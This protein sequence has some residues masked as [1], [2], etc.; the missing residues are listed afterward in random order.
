MDSLLYWLITRH[1]AVKALVLALS[2]LACCCSVLCVVSLPA[3]QRQA[4]LNA[5]QTAEAAP[6]V[7]AQAAR[8]A[9]ATVKAIPTVTAQA[10]IDATQTAAAAP[11]VTARAVLEATK[12]AQ[13]IATTTARAAANATQTAE[14]ILA[15]TAQAAEEATETAQAAPTSSPT[16]RTAS[17]STPS[18]RGVSAG[19]TVEPETE[20]EEPKKCVPN[21]AFVTDVTIPDDTVLKPGE[22]FEKVWRIRNSGDCPWD[23]RYRL[24]HADGDKL[25]AS[26]PVQLG[27]SVDVGETVDISVKMQAPE[28]DDSYTSWWEMQD[29]LG[30]PFGRRVY[31]RVAVT[32][33]AEAE[34]GALMSSESLKYASVAKLQFYVLVRIGLDSL[35]ELLINPRPDDEPWLREVAYASSFVEVG[36][37]KFAEMDAPVEIS[38]I[39]IAFAEAYDECGGLVDTLVADGVE[40]MRKQTESCDRQLSEAGD[41]LDEVLAKH[42]DAF[43]AQ[44]VIGNLA[45][46]RVNQ[47]EDVR[48]GMLADDVVKT[49]PKETSTKEPEVLAIDSHGLILRY[50]YPDVEL[51]IARS[52]EDGFKRGRVQQ[53]ILTGTDEL[54]EN[55][56]HQP[57]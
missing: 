4:E 47:W 33:T 46:T 44:D 45:G 53:I 15:V 42:L 5:T 24:V 12:T 6:T 51:I 18:G 50:F 29:D 27:Q 10:A 20:T 40:Q 17:T 26:G 7:T 30:H 11:T 34:P 2:M 57:Q 54:I 16:S 25:G 9:T 22:A 1:P 31:V 55:E 32:T 13:A 28:N 36:R 39:H 56:D 43:E 41:M 19:G 21:V 14:S 23:G 48:V 8:N 3:A 52:P 38:H 37:D 35:T 49:H